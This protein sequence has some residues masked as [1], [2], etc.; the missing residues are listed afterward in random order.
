MMEEPFLLRMILTVLPSLMKQD[1]IGT[2]ILKAQV[3]EAFNEQWID[4]HV[5]NISNKLSELRVQTNFKKIKL[6]F[7]QYCQD[8]AFEMFFQGSQVATENDYK[9]YEYD[10][11]WSKLDPTMEMEIKH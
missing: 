7:Q 10:N 1:F 8:L 3:Y 9:E 4:I 6:A 2:K 5:K 11:I